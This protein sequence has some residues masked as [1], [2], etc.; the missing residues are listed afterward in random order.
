MNPERTREIISICNK[1]GT[2]SDIT[3]F[4]YLWLLGENEINYTQTQLATML[5]LEKRTLRGHLYRLASRGLIESTQ[6]Y[7]KP[8]TIKLKRFRHN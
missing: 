1:E 4:M 2:G 5:Q 8:N 6:H 3:T 7:S